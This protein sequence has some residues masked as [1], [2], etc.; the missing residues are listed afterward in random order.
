MS[1]K[2]LGPNRWA[3]KVSM[4]DKR[5][6]YPVSKQTT[7]ATRAE[8]VQAEADIQKALKTRSLTGTCAS[9]F[10]EAVDLYLKK[11]AAA[12]KGSASHKRMYMYLKRDLGHLRLETF[13]DYFGG[14]LRAASTQI[15]PQGRPR[16]AAS[17]N[18]YTAMVRAV[19]NYLVDLELIDRNPIT[20]IRFPLSAEKPRDRYLSDI[21]RRNLLT[22][23]AEHRP[24][25]LPIVTYMLAVPSRVSELTSARRE[26]Y[27]PLNNTIYIPDSKANI[28]IHKP[29]PESMR[30]Y[31]DSIPEDCPYLFG[32]KR[33]GVYKP[34]T[35]A[36]RKAWA[37]CLKK[38][39]IADMRIHDLRHMAVT[40]LCR[41]G[42]NPQVV[43]A[44]AGWKSTDM[45]KHYY[46]MDSLW[47]A[48][49]TVFK[50]AVG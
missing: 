38:A 31:F 36:L 20:K 30:S 33:G 24:A 2:K 14:Y 26:Q 21:E 19:F 29:I 16:K 35:F 43:A 12:G 47:A 42:N 17:I 37:F 8:A 49:S 39:G 9:T 4:W 27:I 10:G 23:I 41:A 5:K 28:P 46:H 44:T 3:V 15:T 7:V 6:G 48:Q 11:T 45:L 25:I 13:A 22:A 1:I 32:Y 34:L 50:T 40:D 18:R